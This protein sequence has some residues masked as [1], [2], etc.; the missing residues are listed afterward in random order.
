MPAMRRSTRNLNRA[1][2]LGLLMANAVGAF[3][4]ESTKSVRLLLPSPANAAVQQIGSVF[5][6]QIRQR[7]N[8]EVVNAG[9]ALLTVELAVA[10]GIGTEGF[11]IED[12]VG[13]GVRIVGND[14]RGL[15][16]GAGKFLRNGRYGADGFTPGT[17]RG[18][19]SPQKPVR[20]IY[21]ATHFH[22]FYHDAPVEEVQRYVE[23]LGLWGFNALAFW[24]D[25]RYAG[26]GI[27][28]PAAV[29]F[30][31]RLRALGQAAKG[32]GLDV[33]LIVVGNDS[34]TNAPVALRADASGMRGAIYPWNVC[35][36]KPEGM[37]YIL[38]VLGQEFDWAASLAPHYVI[39]W[40]YD[41]GG[42]GCDQCRPWGSNGFLRATQAVAALARQKLPGT[43]II[44]STWFFDEGEW[45]GLRQAFADRR[46]LVDFILAEGTARSMPAGLPMVGFPEISMHATF[47]WGGFG[48]TPLPR[49]AEQ[50]WD[51]VRHA[52]HGGFP[53]SEGIYEDITK[54]VIAQLYWNDR[55]A[56]ETLREYAAFEYSP[57]VADDVVR[58]IAT[59][60]QNHH[61]RW[62]PGELA[63]VK[64]DLDW[65]PSRGA[66][67]QADPGAEEAYATVQRIDE[68]LS[69]QARQAWR[70]RLLYLRALLDAELKAN[71][72][73]PNARCKEAFAELIQIYHA[74]NANPAVRPPL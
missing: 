44:L 21:F 60:E 39:V 27:D 46:P 57:A 20:G 14:E 3:P 24:Y 22:N 72:G 30:R 70:W 4:A 73:A 74:Q 11:R 18:T 35:P 33:A 5:T 36:S 10:P 62:W 42:C 59:L 71:G 45:Q 6:R 16:Y 37:N 28:D 64:L 56:E 51:L 50:Q 43:K 19:S 15:L 25:M 2:S 47:P 8:V 17:W 54:A 52:S 53:Y 68:R 48:A 55:P 40:P 65:F 23:D 32:I 58:V 38:K 63:G 49:R 31:A 69:P 1:L 12:R 29:E 7:C 26:A 41:S 9:E 13:G 34:Y 67:R 61:M 66:P